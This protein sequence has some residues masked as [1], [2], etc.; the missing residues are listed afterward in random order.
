M[1]ALPL[2]P[3][4]LEPARGPCVGL[5]WRV[6]ACLLVDRTPLE[7]AEP[8]GDRLT[9]FTGH[10]EFWEALRAKGLRGLRAASYPP[11]MATTE[12]DEWP[13]GRVVYEAPEARFAVY[14]DRRLKAPAIIGAVVLAFGLDASRYEVRSD[15]HYR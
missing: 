13:R 5:F 3:A 15:S 8:Y 12:Y 4:G 2:A 9:H 6:G 14:A 1:T 7:S 11:E 10:Y